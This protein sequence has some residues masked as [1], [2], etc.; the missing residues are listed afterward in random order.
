MGQLQRRA[1]VP[2]M[3]GKRRD[4]HPQ[5]LSGKWIFEFP[6]FTAAV[7]HKMLGICPASKDVPAGRGASCEMI[8]AFREMIAVQ[9]LLIRSFQRLKVG[10]R[11]I[12]AQP[13]L[14]VFC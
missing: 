6:G 10:G 5:R 3:T 11:K 13:E 12:V 2:A 1:C 4:L 7:K 9:K 14:F 8:M